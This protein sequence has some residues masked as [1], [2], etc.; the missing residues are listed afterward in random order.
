MILHIDNRTLFSVWVKRD[1]EIHIM[2]VTLK[3]FDN[4]VIQAATERLCEQWNQKAAQMPCED[5]VHT[6]AVRKQ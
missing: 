1:P 3:A 4:A 6:D 5:S 2:L